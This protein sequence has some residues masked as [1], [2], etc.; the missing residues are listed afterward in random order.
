M[1]FTINWQG[2]AG[3]SRMHGFEEATKN[4]KFDIIA[5]TETRREG[6]NLLRKKNGNYLFHFWQQKASVERFYIQKARTDMVM[7][8]KGIS[9]SINTL[10]IEINSKT[11]ILTIQTYA[12]T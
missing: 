1:I 5:V 7:E 6:K 3:K 2:L 11:K 4:S 10:K 8:V 9:E 12:P